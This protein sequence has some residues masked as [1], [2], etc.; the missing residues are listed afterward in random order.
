MRVYVVVEGQTEESVVNDVLVPHFAPM[1]V[2]LYPI[3]VRTSRGHRRGGS[4]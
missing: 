4:H 1:E 2:Y 3:I